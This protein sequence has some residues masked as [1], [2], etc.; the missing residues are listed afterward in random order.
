MSIVYTPLLT[1]S[2]ITSIPN[3]SDVRILLVTFALLNVMHLWIPSFV[4]NGIL[5]SPKSLI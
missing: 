1:S 3:V 5:F 2:L 4:L